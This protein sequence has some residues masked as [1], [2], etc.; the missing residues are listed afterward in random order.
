MPAS[1]TSSSTQLPSARDRTDTVDPVSLYLQAFSSR[2]ATAD[3]GWRRSP[4]PTCRL[5]TSTSRWP[6]QLQ[7]AAGGFARQR[8]P[9]P[10]V[11]G[12]LDEGVAVASADEGGGGG[13]A[14][15]L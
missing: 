3:T 12:R 15:H 1:A 13:V 9:Q 2:L 8:R 4:R 14:H 11:H 7:S 5:R 10:L 6:E